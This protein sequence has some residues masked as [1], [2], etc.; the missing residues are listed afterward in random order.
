MDVP[1]LPADVQSRL[2]DFLAPGASVRNPVD[3]I[4]TAS[5]GDYRRTVET[6]IEAQVCDAILTIFVP[7]LV[8]EARDVAA[9][10]VGVAEDE[11]GVPIAAVFMTSEGLP[12]ELSSEGTQVPGYQ[13]P[14]DA[15]RAIALAAKHGR[16]RTRPRQERWLA[17]DTRPDE[18]AAVISQQLASGPCWVELDRVVAL[19]NCYGLPQIETRVV[20]SVAEA[21]DKLG[22]LGTPVVLKAIAP[23]L[24]H[25]TDAGGVRLGL[26][27]PEQVRAAAAEIESA[28]TAAGYR[29]D[30]FA[31]Q[32]MAPEGIELILGVV[33]DH[34][35]G[36][37]IACGAGGTTGELIKDVSVRITP[38]SELDASEM[39]RALQTFPLLDG[40]RGARRC[41]MKAIENVLLRLSVMVEAHPEIVELDF[42]PLIATPDGAVIVDARVRVESAPAPAPVASLRA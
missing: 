28:V 12:T 19:L 5:A 37:V 6:L 1:E 21:V 4:A 23:D 10:I 3:M 30:G 22:E 42:N 15:A 24:V 9:A 13:F 33:N 7:T 11:P 36:P 29:L 32:P 20:A 38:L 8:T 26:A 16:W 17:T 27:G 25:K 34:N 40:Y 39:I 14:E 18:A 41:N 31:V 35:F 2:A